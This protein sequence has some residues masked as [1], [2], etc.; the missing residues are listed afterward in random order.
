MDKVIIRLLSNSSEVALFEGKLGIFKDNNIEAKPTDLAILSGAFRDSKGFTPYWT[1]AT[2]KTFVS[3]ITS[4]DYSPYKHHEADRFAKSPAIR[5]VIEISSIKDR[6]V[7]KGDI[8]KDDIVY[9]GEYGLFIETDEDKIIEL[10][11]IARLS[12]NYMTTDKKY[13]LDDKNLYQ[14]YVL[15]GEKYIRFVCTNE[16]E[17]VL[18]NGEICVKDKPYWLKVDKI[19]WLVDRE[20]GLLVSQY[21]LLAG[22]SYWLENN[23]EESFEK[24]NMA[25]FLN[26]KMLQDIMT[27]STIKK[28][29]SYNSYLTNN[30][31]NLK[32]VELGLQPLQ[33]FDTKFEDLRQSNMNYLNNNL[34][35]YLILMLQ[36]NY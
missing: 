27:I 14:E 2:G 25:S 10:D 36:L 23:G 35:N 20:K 17:Q 3:V 9:M 1:S 5:P 21:A 31:F 26:D 22:I 19:P 24:S 32:V 8:S 18:S 16:D 7:I 30:P 6:R 13:N 29:N 11:R 28:A 4:T 34:I 15:N 33:I 12:K